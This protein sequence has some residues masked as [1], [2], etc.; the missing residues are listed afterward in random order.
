MSLSLSVS[1]LDVIVN[2]GSIVLETELSIVTDGRFDDILAVIFFFRVAE[3]SQIRMLQE[4]SSRWSLFRVK[5]KHT[6][7]KL[8]GF[9]RSAS[10]EPFVERF[11]LCLT[12]L[13]NH[14]ASVICSQ[15]VYLSSAWFAGE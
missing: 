3:V 14:C 6:D 1:S 13:L 15:R 4:L 9:M 2:Q 5:L 7:H 12:H 11:L 8:N 10:L